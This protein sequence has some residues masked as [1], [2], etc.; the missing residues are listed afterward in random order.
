MGMTVRTAIRLAVRLAV[1]G[2]LF[3][4]RREIFAYDLA[5]QADGSLRGV[6]RDGS[7]HLVI[8]TTN[9]VFRTPAQW[10]QD[11]DLSRSSIVLIPV[12]GDWDCER[13]RRERPTRRS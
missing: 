2:D 11:P 5:E 9:E 13:L 4:A 12:E 8:D 6:V 10:V 3:L 7:E 1:A